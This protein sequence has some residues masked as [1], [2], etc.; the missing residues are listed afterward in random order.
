MKVHHLKSWISTFE[1]VAHGSCQQWPKQFEIRRNDRDFANGDTVVLW[2]FNAAEGALTGRF[3]VLTEIG[4]VV[5]GRF[6]L[7]AGLCVFGWRHQ[8]DMGQV[9]PADID[10]ARRE[11]RW[12]R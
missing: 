2:E 4:P 11:A 10:R 8:S 7:P 12:S 6:G 1:N 3:V 9:A 5:D